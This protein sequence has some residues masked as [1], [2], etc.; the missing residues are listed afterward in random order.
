MYGVLR[1]SKDKTDN[2]V[3]ITKVTIHKTYAWA[4]SFCYGQ[5]V[6]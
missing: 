1:V 3:Q 4:L 5:Y 2:P 6:R